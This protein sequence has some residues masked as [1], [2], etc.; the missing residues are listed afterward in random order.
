MD[1]AITVSQLN[2]Y[3]KLKIDH[4]VKLKDVYIS[5]EISNFINHTKSG[6][7]Y[8]TL[9]DN[10]SIIKTIMFRQYAEKINLTLCDGLK[11]V[12]RGQV[13]VFERD[14]TYQVY[15]TEIKL[16]GEG[17]LSQ[18]FEFLKEKLR[19]QGLFDENHKKAIPKYPERIGIITA[20]TGAAIRDI[21]N[22]FLRRFPYA[23][24][25]LY[26]ALVQGDGAAKT[27]VDG[28]NFFNRKNG[29]D[30]ILIGR[31][32]GSAED[33]WCFN[34]EELA[35]TVYNSV[36]PVISCVGHETDFTIIDYVADL[37]APTPSAAAE[38][39]A[40]DE[41]AIRYQLDLLYKKI[42]KNLN[43]KIDFLSKIL[44]ALNNRESLKNREYYIKSREEKLTSLIS[45]P[46]LKNPML[47]LE[48]NDAKLELLAT[49]LKSS[50]SIKQTKYESDF[51]KLCASIDMLSPL[52]VLSR[53]YA[54]VTKDD[55]HITASNIHVNDEVLINFHDGNIT[56]S[57]KECKLYE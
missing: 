50:V 9:K 18:K 37:R 14:G 31:G 23:K 40:P 57:V 32:G 26:P 56:A 51:A 3:I 6:H 5:G 52:K 21:E 33:L 11:V 19:N 35:L 17:D 53:G 7:C 46:I 24:L 38:L 20:P 12:V 36:I 44:D 39:S 54:L 1:K 48:K 29:I 8:F 41:N 4:D 42:E 10:D 34:D 28:I 30:V 43:D 55:E 22:V 45:R 13:S 27:L 15:A 2:R 25:Y 47:Y 49:R 16:D